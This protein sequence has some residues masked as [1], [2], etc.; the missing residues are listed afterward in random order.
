[1]KIEGFQFFIPAKNEYK[2]AHTEKNN[3]YTFLTLKILLYLVNISHQGNEM[4][5]YK[6]T[7]PAFMFSFTIILLIE[8]TRNRR[9]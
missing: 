9:L 3:D 2:Y 7:V 5:I 4:L 1:M 6:V 8:V